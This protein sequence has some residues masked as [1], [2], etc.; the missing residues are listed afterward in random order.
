MNPPDISPDRLR[1]AAL[2]LLERVLPQER[3]FAVN[4]WEQA[5]L[6]AGSSPEKATLLI[7]SPEALG[8]M[9]QPPLDLS[10]GESFLRGDL[11]VEGDLEAVFAAVEGVTPR[12][13]VLQLP[14]LLKDLAALRRQA[15]STLAA[16]L[17]G[18]PHSKARDRA[19]IQHHY[20]I[21][22]AFYRLWLDERMVYSCAYFPT[23]S[24]TLDQAQEAKLEHVCKKLRL[25]RGERF[26]DVGCGWG[27]L[28]IYAARR[29]G[30]EALGITL[31][32]RQLEEARARVK[33]AGLEG[34]VRVELLDYR[35]VE[36]L[37][38]KVASVGMAEHVG[39]EN[40]PAYFRAAWKCLR[41]GGLMLHHVITQGPVVLAAEKS[42]ASGAFMKRY[43]FP[44]GEILPLWHNLQAAESVGFEVRDVE[45]LREHYA[46]TLRQ[47]IR[48][49]E[50]RWGEAAAEVGL[51]RARLWRLYMAA[52]AHQFAY[53]HLSVHQTLLARPGER[54]HVPLPPSRAD[55]YRTG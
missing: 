11:E 4:L 38:D 42:L 19:A 17:R 6:P 35:E 50:A 41:P 51:E 2:S 9:F 26:L 14:T 47:W 1:E 53:G 52:S 16:R 12:L 32:Q 24:E 10:L 29:Y 20:D 25:E 54:G 18:A 49:L 36:G 22:N 13:S 46:L 7:R 23:G 39:R 43:V 21:S 27:G 45:D 44:D 37:F 31:S 28:V 33:R 48:N 34:R 30:V 40:L 3:S 55:L 8:R 15:G 5:V